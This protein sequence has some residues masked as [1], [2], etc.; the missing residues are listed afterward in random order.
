MKKIISLTI[1]AALAVTAFTGCSKPASTS[2]K[3]STG[4]S[5]TETSTPASSANLKDGQYSAEFDHVDGKGWKPFLNIEVKDGKITKADFNYKSPDG[6]LKT[7]DE[8]YE[9]NMK[10]KNN[11]GPVEYVPKYNDNIIKKQSADIDVVTGAT[12]SGDNVKVLLKALLDKA[13]KGDTAKAVL[14]MNDT[15]TA[16]EKDFDDHGWKASVSVT[17][18]NDKVTK[19]VFDE[20]N[21]DGKKKSEDAAYNKSMKDA[22]GISAKEA[23]DLLVKNYVEKGSVDAVAKATGTSTKFKTLLQ[24]ALDS[25]K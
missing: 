22:N 15:Y 25:R 16:T 2:G 18:E 7:Q 1:A 8:T 24:Q 23:A 6:K 3:D 11:L 14:K 5:N 19:V 12:H 20:V 17:F 10:A 4:K 9:K 13:A 21:K